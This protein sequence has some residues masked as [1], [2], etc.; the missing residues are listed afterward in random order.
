[1]SLCVPFDGGKYEIVQDERYHVS[2]LRHGKS[3]VANPPGQRFLV[4]V[5]FQVHA[6]RRLAA[7][8][9]LLREALDVGPER[10]A[11]VAGDL[12]ALR[13]ELRGLADVEPDLAMPGTV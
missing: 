9:L 4:E 11:A 7:A 13:A 10:V 2:V 12:D 3:W 8:G 1:M 5:A 6:L